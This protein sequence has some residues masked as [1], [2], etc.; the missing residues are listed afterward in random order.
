MLLLNTLL[1]VWNAPDVDS[2][3]YTKPSSQQ[4]SSQQNS[5]HPNSSQQNS[6][7][8]NS[9]Q[10]E[11]GKDESH[12]RDLGAMVIGGVRFQAFCEGF[13]GPQ[14]TRLLLGEPYIV[15]YVITPACIAVDSCML[16]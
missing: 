3:S 2:K 4:N 14:T 7:H 1:D 11:S 12:R 5:S 13:F 16:V 9:S 10:Q 15:T 6:S 8:E